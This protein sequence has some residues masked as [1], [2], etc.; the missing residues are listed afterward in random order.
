[1]RALTSLAAAAA[2]R[3]L[4]FDAHRRL[5]P[6]VLH[7]ACGG[8]GHADARG[9]T[10]RATRFRWQRTRQPRIARPQSR[11]RARTRCGTTIEFHPV[12]APCS[13]CARAAR[14]SRRGWS[15]R[16]SA[17]RPPAT[18][19]TRVAGA[20]AG[21]SVRCTGAGTR[22]PEH[23]LGVVRRARW[24]AMAPL[25]EDLEVVGHLPVDDA[26]VRGRRRCPV[27]SASSRAAVSASVSP[28]SRLPVTDCQCSGK[29]ARS[30]SSTRRSRV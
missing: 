29:S 17:A 8:A 15:R 14:G 26:A 28:G 11:Q 7:G 6:V 19:A 27:S 12:A 2:T 24:I 21:C 1:M 4:R 20:R 18:A 16:S 3:I 9:R 22:Q 13:A 5:H 10:A 23:V 30:S 25:R